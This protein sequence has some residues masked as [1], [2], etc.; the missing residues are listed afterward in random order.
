MSGEEDKT[1]ESSSEEK[2]A[3]QKLSDRLV[4]LM[5]R[6]SESQNALTMAQI[7]AREVADQSIPALLQ[8]TE[9]LL[10]GVNERVCL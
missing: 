2:T 8:K 7:Q 10:H 1:P 6:L 3:K 4:V 5:K 9:L